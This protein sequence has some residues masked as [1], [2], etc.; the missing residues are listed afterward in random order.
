M[1]IGHSFKAFVMTSAFVAGMIGLT[2]IPV[3]AKIEQHTLKQGMWDEDVKELQRLL[4]EIGYFHYHKPTGFYGPL[5][6]KSVTA[7]QKANG[8]RA[9][10]I[11]GPETRAALNAIIGKEL[12]TRGDYGKAVRKLQKQLAEL[13]YYTY[14]IDGIFGPRTEKAVRQ[15]QTASDIA[16]DGI[17]G[18]KTREMLLFHPIAKEEW[19]K[20]DIA[21]SQT[22]SRSTDSVEESV[23]TLIMESTAY[24]ANCQ[25]CSGITATGINLHENPD[26][27]VVAVDP[28]VIPLGSTV[29][30]EG[31]GYAIAADVGGGID[32]KEID[33]YFSDYNRAI[34]WGRKQVKVKVLN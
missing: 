16:V 32:G 10:G 28:D 29:W 13:G 31:Y 12:L 11:V 20:A 9:D 14:Q 22:V 30:V 1:R 27:K 18:P 7:F 19:K 26:V 24:T 6:E 23:Q 4:G 15:F 2:P 3:D 34:E 8:L 17:V 5:T 33:V 21:A 25:G